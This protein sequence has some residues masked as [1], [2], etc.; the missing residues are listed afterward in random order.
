MSRVVALDLGGALAGA[1]IGAVVGLLV[2]CVAALMKLFLASGKTCPGCG[3]HIP[4]PGWKGRLRG[5]WECPACGR[6]VNGQGKP[7][8]KRRRHGA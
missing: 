7:V 2:G 1:I 4:K 3:S 6:V 8:K 5:R